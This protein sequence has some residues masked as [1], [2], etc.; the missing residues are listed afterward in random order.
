MNVGNE[1]DGYALLDFA[2]GFSGVHIRHRDAYD[3]C[4]G[5][6]QLLDLADGGVH[7]QGIGVGHALYGNRRI[8][9][10]GHI[11]NMNLA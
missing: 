10:H 1:G 6:F 9:A 4:S 11:A 8:A 2:E 5:F 7:I 3:I